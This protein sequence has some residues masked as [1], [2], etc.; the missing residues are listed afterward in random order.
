M[1][2][3]IERL[4]NIVTEVDRHNLYLPPTIVSLLRIHGFIPHRTYTRPPRPPRPPPPVR[5][6][7]PAMTRAG[8]PCKNKCAVGCT[9]CRIHVA[10]PNPRTPRGLPGVNE[11][12][13]ETVKGGTQCKCSKY[14]QY[15]MCWRHAKKANLLPP[16][17]E[18]PTECAVCYCDLTRETTTK[19]ACG[20]HFHI[21][22]FETWRQSRSAS[23]QAV[24][25]PMCR[26][27]NPRPKPLVRR[28]LG[29]AHQSSPANVL[30]L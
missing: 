5:V 4:I 3:I 22:C 7:C 26:H 13:P 18:V 12:C 20:H 14:K 10:N 30:V 27:A 24:T 16:T 15:P 1:A 25:C 17:P 29:T 23:F 2:T 9:T 11:R 6:Q 28:A 8:T 19:T 21:A